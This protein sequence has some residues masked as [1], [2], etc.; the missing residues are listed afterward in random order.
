MQV[1]HAARL[2]AIAMLLYCG[3]LCAPRS[4]AAAALPA[5]IIGVNLHPLQDTYAE[6]N[7][8]RALDLAA[9][10]G[11]SIVRIDIHWWWF[12]WRGQS[13]SSW[14]QE[15]VHALDTFLAAAQRRHIQVLATIQDTPCWAIAHPAPHCSDAAHFNGNRGPLDPGTYARFLR[16]LVAHVG[17]RIQYYEI[18]NEPNIHGFWLHPDPAAYTRLLKAAYTAIKRMDPEAVVL[19]GA[20]SGADTRF[21]AGMYA[22]GAKGF[23]DALSIHPYS[24]D[25]PPDACT[26]PRHSFEC[27]VEAVHHLMLAHGDTHPLWLTELGA[28]VGPGMDA[29][30]Q[31]QYVRAALFCVAEWPYVRGAIWYELYDD[32]TGHDGQHFGLFDSTLTA[33]PAAAAFREA[34]HAVT[35]A[36]T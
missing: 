26:N 3:S 4:L 36:R 27:G 7:P 24:G 10:V 11:A 13:R 12:E 25:R 28:E 32:P 16:R 22:A 6:V 19:A 33:R 15:Q 18:W 34:D 23:Y 2:L 8:D 1:K 29:D 9:Q 14:D 30:A 35:R 17:D 20:T 5:P 31:A 21:I